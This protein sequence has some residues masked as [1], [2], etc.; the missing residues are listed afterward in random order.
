MVRTKI[1]TIPRQSSIHLVQN[2]CNGAGSETIQWVS[3]TSSRWFCTKKQTEH[4]KN[5]CLQLGKSSKTVS[6]PLVE[7][8]LRNSPTHGL[9]N[10]AGAETCRRFCFYRP[11]LQ[12]FGDALAHRSLARDSVAQSPQDHSARNHG[13][14]SP[15]VSESLVTADPR[16]IATCSVPSTERGR[17]QRYMHP[18]AGHLDR[19]QG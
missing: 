13:C 17:T 18:D 8:S 5:L 15:R 1:R 19:Q 7:G 10:N 6:F 4:R 2:G 3:A 11:L 9:T 12:R 16:V 14:V